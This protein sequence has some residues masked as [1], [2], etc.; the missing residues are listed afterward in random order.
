MPSLSPSS[1]DPQDPLAEQPDY[2][3]LLRALVSRAIEALQSDT[4]FAP[5]ACVLTVD[6]ELR[7]LPQPT[8]AGLSQ[9]DCERHFAALAAEAAASGSIVAAGI[10][11]HILMRGIAMGDYD[12]VSSE[13]VSEGEAIA[14]NLDHRDSEPFGLHHPFRWRDDGLQ[15]A[16]MA[17]KGFARRFAF[18]VSGVRGGVWGAG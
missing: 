15:F 14:F 13:G 3:R 12:G 7:D 10:V 8:E 11:S 1:A 18:V 17:M 6:G 5:M 2:V 16:D 4:S 9:I